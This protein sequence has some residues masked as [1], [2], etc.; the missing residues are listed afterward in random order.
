MFLTFA[1]TKFDDIFSGYQPRQVYVPSLS[2]SSSSSSSMTKMILE[3]SV[4][5]G[6]MTQLIAREDFIA[7]NS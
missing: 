6:H 2:S 4:Q 7:L 3:T 1:A 5:Y